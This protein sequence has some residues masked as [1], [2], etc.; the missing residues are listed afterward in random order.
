MN[1][2]SILYQDMVRYACKSSDSISDVMLN[3]DLAARQLAL[4]SLA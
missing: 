1:L 3:Q 4:V 2:K